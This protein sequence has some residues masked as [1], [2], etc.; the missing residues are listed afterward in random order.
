[1]E[2]THAVPARAGRGLPWPLRLIVTT[3][4]SAVAGEAAVR[5]NLR[6]LTVLTAVF[7]VPDIAQG[8][9]T[10]A[11]AAS[12]GGRLYGAYVLA[13]GLL[14]LGGALLLA[15]RRPRGR[16]LILAAPPRRRG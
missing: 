2:H 13:L 12:S 10:V 8:A 4:T 7:S 9:L 6:L 11:G 14:E 15:V 5:F 1:M 16:L 3:W